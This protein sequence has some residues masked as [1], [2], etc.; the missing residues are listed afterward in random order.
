MRTQ[1]GSANS[2]NLSRADRYSSIIIGAAIRVHRQL[3]PG[4]LESAYE[5][6]L[7]HE[8]SRQD[9]PFRRQVGMR[10]EYAGEQV[11]CAFRADIIV[12]NLVLLEIKSV[13]KL[14]PVHLAQV[15]TYLRIAGLPL[16]LLLNFNAVT[17]TRGIR[18]LVNT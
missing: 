16:G 14:L 12:D 18:R 13:E 8:L 7:C 3:G 6:C 4:L 2:D 11:D 10:M 9:L 17:M 15:L 1:E 5:T